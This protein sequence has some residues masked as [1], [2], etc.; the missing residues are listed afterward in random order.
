MKAQFNNLAQWFDNDRIQNK[1]KYSIDESIDWLR[2]IPF[3]GLHLGCFAVFFVGWSMTSIVVALILYTVRM[4]AITGF[5]HRYF[6]HRTF[7]TSRFIQF[8]FAVLGASAVQRGPLWW[9]SY[10]RY[11]HKYSDTKMDIHS[12]S[13]SGF[14]KSHMFWFM[15][16][17]NFSTKNDLIK[18][19]IKF[20][21]LRILDR[22]DI[23]IPFLLAVGLFIFGDILNSYKPEW[24][25]NG[26]QL[27]VWGFFISTVLLFHGTCSTNSLAHKFG[28]RRYV[29]GDDSRNNLIIS[30]ITLGEGWHNNHHH[31]PNSVNQGFYWWEID[32]TYW[33]LKI[34]SVFGII[35]DLKKVPENILKSSIISQK[36]NN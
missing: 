35:W 19:L 9:S 20:P 1:Y 12:P 7:K 11:H 24:G 31:Y 27:L 33:I 5:Y 26:P 8:L 2:C 6:S 14:W 3:V 30:L 23:V 10:H 36:N 28:N 15:G 29:T 18:D 17:S 16:K 21:E 13:Q 25:A 32:I 22:F 4:F 34:L